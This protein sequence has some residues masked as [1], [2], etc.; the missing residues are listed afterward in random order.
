M[1]ILDKGPGVVNQKANPGKTLA[2]NF[3]KYMWVGA[4]TL[5]SF[6]WSALVSCSKWHRQPGYT[7]TSHFAGQGTLVNGS[8]LWV[9]IATLLDWG[10]R[11]SGG[12][13]RRRSHQ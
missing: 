4:L 7:H 13:R 3:V 10:Y 12:G 1:A 11:R 5:P 2:V 6:L 8:I 9:F